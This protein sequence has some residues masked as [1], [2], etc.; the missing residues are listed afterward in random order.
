MPPRAVEERYEL[1]RR[2]GHGGMATVYLAHDRKL[3]RPVAVKVLADNLAGDDQFRLRFVREARLAAQLDHPNVVQVYDVEED[4]DRPFIVME[5]VEGETLAELVERRSEGL[6]VREAASLLCQ[7][8]EGLGH[9][10]SRGLVHR[11]VKPQNLLIRRSDCCVKV[12]DFGIARAAEDT[13]L[14]QTGL[15]IGTERYMA[16][17]QTSGGQLTP[18]TDVYSCGVVATEML[19]PSRRRPLQPVIDRCL[20]HDPAAR[21]RDGREL[22]PELVEG[23][24]VETARARLEACRVD[25]VRRTD[26]RH[27]HGQLRVLA[28]ERARGACVIEVDVRE[29]QVPEVADLDASLR[30]ALA[31]DGQAARRAAVVE[32]EAVVRLDEVG[33]D[34][35]GV[36][37]VQEVEGLVRHAERP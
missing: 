6:T 16:P 9:A 5:L 34:A 15:V 25:E 8:S 35:P 20:A 26:L 10:H 31:E 13:S 3:E 36:A 24:A 19:P 1:D 37:A 21:F 27:V 22:A 14:T 28:D 7:A 18:A 30:E 2:L 17:E 11:D 32:R 29:Q 23:V 4:A 33:A 12:V